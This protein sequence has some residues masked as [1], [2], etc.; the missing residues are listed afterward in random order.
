MIGDMS[1]GGC[2]TSD[3]EDAPMNS[4]ITIYTAEGELYEATRT[5][6]RVTSFNLPRN[7]IYIIKVGEKTFKVKI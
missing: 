2:S 7:A 5:K 1:E 6:E 3:I 4:L